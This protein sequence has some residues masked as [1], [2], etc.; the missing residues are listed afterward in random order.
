MERGSNSK[1]WISFKLALGSFFSKFKAL[2]GYHA[3]V[4][5]ERVIGYEGMSQAWFALSKV[6]RLRRSAFFDA[7]LAM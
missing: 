7:N 6:N 3:L 4:L 1:L 5:D 2:V